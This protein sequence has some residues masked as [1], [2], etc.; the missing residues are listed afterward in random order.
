MDHALLNARNPG[1][2]TGD[3]NNTYLLA[4]RVPTLIDAGVGHADHLDEIAS[5]LGAATLARVV[6]THAHIDHASGAPALAA[7]WPGAAFEKLP[8]PE[9]DG[10]WPV[11]WRA[12]ADGG[13]IDAGDGRLLVV[14]T[15]GHSP[16]HIALLD[17][18]SG[19]LFAG[20]LVVAG[21]S[22]VIP[23]GR[24]GDL[25]AY[26]R[27]L[28]RVLALGP[29]RL[30]PAHGPAIDDPAKV[31]RGYLEHRRA[32]EEQ[33]LDALARGP[34]RPEELVAFIYRG[35]RPEL[36]EAAAGSVVAHLIKL[37]D[38]GRAAEEAAGCWRRLP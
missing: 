31:I 36:R 10:R 20:D 4:G 7:R 9:R 19:T 33:I 8:W 34:A 5:R 29:R 16:D 22:V 13:E 25:A 21:S 37:R 27:S 3:G 17:A 15:P 1:P 14:H 30:L 38:E 35:L 28:E 18:G 12:L 26:L 11:A 6:V 2:W 32:R 23:A 24:G